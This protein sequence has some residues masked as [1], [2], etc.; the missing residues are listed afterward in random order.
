MK[1]TLLL[2]TL[3]EIDG[4]RQILP[5]IDRT[6]CDQIIV[7]DGGSTDGTV[8]WAREQGCEVHVQTRKGIRYAYFEVFPKIT[9]DVVISF[10]PDGNCPVDAIPRLKEKMAEGYDLVIASRYLPGARSDD[11]DIMTAFGNW[12]FTRTVN[13]LHGAHYTDVMVILRA[14]RKSLVTGLDLMDDAAYAGVERLFGTVISWEPLMSVR[15][16]KWGARIAEIPADEPA[17]IGGERKLQMWRWGAAYYSQ[18]WRELW[19]WRTARNETPSSIAPSAQ[20]IVK[21]VGQV[22]SH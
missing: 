1:T 12:L 20:R 17:R 11:D 13:L 4:M 16:A 7:V 8:E 15:A 10:S 21:N 14:F 3:N 18:F 19:F 5:L 2:L 22:D 9:G 6:W